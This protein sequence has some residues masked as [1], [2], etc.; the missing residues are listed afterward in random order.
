MNV[1]RALKL[2]LAWVLALTITT[3]CTAQTADYY[4]G[5]VESDKY[6]VMTSVSGEVEEI[7]IDEGTTVNVG[8]KIACLDTQALSIEKKRLEAVLAGAQADMDRVLKGARQEEINQIYQQIAQQDDQVMILKDQLSHTSDTYD[9]T[10]KL[11]ESGAASKQQLD[12]TA[13]AKD[14]ATSRLEQASAQRRLLKEQLNLVLEGATEEE[15]L[16]AKSRV[17]A[18][19]WAVE[20]VQDKISNAVITAKHSGTIDTLYFNKGEQYV[21]LSKFADIVD[22]ENTT[23]RIYVEEKNLHRVEVGGQVR[24]GVD[25][26]TSLNLVGHIEYVASEGEF[27]PK[28][29]ESKENRQEVVY[30]IRIRIEDEDRVL[31]PGMLVDVFLGDDS[32]A[33]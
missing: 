21:A 26:D 19:Q 5:T 13:L 20:A 12:D 10:N 15:V 24:V 7:Y 16:A 29:L 30:E 25:Y 14:N 4:T 33:K 11:F 22:L 31:K 1:K 17:E 6:G 27:T 23:V 8:D 2:I 18:A 3:G 32:D 28:N 9:K